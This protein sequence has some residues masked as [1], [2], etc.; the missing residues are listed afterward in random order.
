[1]KKVLLMTTVYRVGERIYSIIPKLSEEFEVDVLKTGQ[2]SNQIQWYGDNDLR[3]VFD[4]LY[5][6]Y[7]NNIFYE[8]PSLNQYDLILMDD[9]RYRNGMKEIYEEALSLGIPVI[10][11]QHGNQELTKVLPNLRT[12][13]RTSWDYI[14]V[15]GKKEKKLYINGPFDWTDEQWLNHKGLDFSHGILL[16]GIPCND[17]LGEYE[18]TDKHILIIVNFLGNRNAPFLRFDDK[19][20]YKLGLLELQ[21]EYNKKVVIKIKSR[22]DHSRPMEDFHYLSKILSKE[23]DYEIIMDVE[24]DNKLISDSFI[25]ISAPS[26]F[27]LKSIQKGIPT[28][29]LGERIFQHDNPEEYRK[30]AIRFGKD[31]PTGGFYKQGYGQLGTFYDYKGV[32]EL[33]TQR[34]FDEIQRQYNNGKEVDFIENT[35]E[36]G[37]DFNS[38]KVFLDR[39]RELI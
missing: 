21:K 23:L 25:V 35:V 9:D 13:D 19:V 14:T 22:A 39:I 5:S 4:K 1:M 15:F 12:E 18:R 32:V 31:L 38:T 29:I 24:D 37:I 28:I 33:D 8:V 3:L 20:F 6:E 11:H 36:G 27:P 10:G 16:G 26:V 2:M 17:R 30:S 7:V 34:I